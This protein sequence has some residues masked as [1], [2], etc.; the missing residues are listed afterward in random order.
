MCVH[1]KST[2][3]FCIILIYVDDLNIIG[4]TKDVDE[5]H[6]H[7]KTKFEMKDLSRTKFFLGLQL[8]D[9][10][11][12]ILVHQSAYVLKV[13]E[14]FNLDKTYSARTSMVIR[15]LEKDK[16]PF[17]LK[18]EGEEVLG[19]EY[20]YLSSLGELMYLTNNIRPD[21]AFVV[22][23]FMR[24]SVAPTMCHQNNIKNML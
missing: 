15:A 14:K 10:H 4:H 18:E 11:I 21:I 8:E 12:V 17:R 20:P 5:A 24:H 6:N 3:G 16:D 2:T 13:L 22:S 7:F 23:Y 9:L 19:Q 1:K